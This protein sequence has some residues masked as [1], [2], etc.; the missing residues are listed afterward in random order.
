[1]WMSRFDGWTP[2]GVQ[3]REA[4]TLYAD[5]ERMRALRVETDAGIEAWARSVEPGWF[6][7]ELRWF[8]AAMQRDYARPRDLLVMHMFN[9][10]THHRGQIHAMLTAAGETTGDTD[11][12]F[13][14]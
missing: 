12:A 10:Q 2:P 14:L 6:A 13:I 8:S 4:A 5:F 1:M 3:L 11:L 7:G 9:H